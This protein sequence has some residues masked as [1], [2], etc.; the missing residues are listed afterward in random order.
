MGSLARHSMPRDRPHDKSGA[1]DEYSRREWFPR[2]LLCAGYGLR[3]RR[4]PKARRGPL[5]CQRPLEDTSLGDIEQGLQ[6]L[7][8][9]LAELPPGKVTIQREGS[10]LGA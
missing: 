7:F 5:Y 10:Q 9:E 3:P 8:R 4:T 6:L 2:K 1:S